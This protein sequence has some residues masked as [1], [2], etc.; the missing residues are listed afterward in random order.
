MSHLPAS[1]PHPPWSRLLLQWGEGWKEGEMR[2]AGEVGWERAEGQARGSSGF[3]T[4]GDFSSGAKV[5]EGQ[6]RG[7]G[8]RN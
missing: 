2:R 8:I 6:P 5:A 3:S 4:F 7:Q 1:G